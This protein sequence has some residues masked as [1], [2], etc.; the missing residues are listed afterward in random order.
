MFD[1]GLRAA[2]RRASVILTTGTL[3]LGAAAPGLADRAG[4]P[5]SASPTSASQAIAYIVGQQVPDGGFFGPNQGVGYSGGLADTMVAVLADQGA[6]AD[7]VDRALENLTAN[8]WAAATKRAAYAA[9][10]VM[11]AKAAGADPRQLGGHDYVAQLESFYSPLGYWESQGYANALAAL[12]WLAAGE[13]L[14]AQALTWL[15][16]NQCPD[17]GFGWG[18]TTCLAVSASDV[19]TTALVVNVLI[20]AGLPSD[21]AMVTKARQ[22]LVVAENAQGGFGG[23]PGAATNA[24]S[25][26]LVLSAIAALGEQPRNA[27]WARSAGRDPLTQILT[28]QTASGG[29]LWTATSSG[30]INNYATVQAVP[31]VAG[32][33]YPIKPVRPGD[34]CKRRPGQHRGH[35]DRCG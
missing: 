18:T 22:Y 10:V 6:S 33:A 3:L 1:S 28:L 16:L 26:G 32:Q 9:R 4:A 27:P 25:T 21:D 24:N 12:G 29:F 5:A 19:D 15:R 34:D 23:A 13:R 30:G 2:L 31:G 14:P 11:A 8:G 7:A 35:P 20:A 17:G